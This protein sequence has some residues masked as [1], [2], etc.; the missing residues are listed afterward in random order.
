MF[1]TTKVDSCRLALT[2]A[3]SFELL[4]CVRLQAVV[5]PTTINFEVGTM[6]PSSVVKATDERGEY[7]PHFRRR[8]GAGNV[9]CG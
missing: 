2:R 3:E 1:A 9:L 6:T 5:S 7:R 8:N 4:S